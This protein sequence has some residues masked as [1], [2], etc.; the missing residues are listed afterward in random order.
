M[1]DGIQLNDTGNY[2]IF[3]N[4]QVDPEIVDRIGV[5]LGTSD[6]DSPTA[7]ATGGT[8]NLTMVR[9]K[10]EP[11]LE[12]EPSVGSFSYRRLF[13]RGDTGPLGPSHLES[14]LAV[15]YQKY[16]KFKGPGDLEKFQLNGRAYQDLGNDN[17][18]SLSVHYN[19]NRNAFYRNL[20]KAEIALNGYGFDNDATCT[21]P[22][23]GAGIQ[24]EATTPTGT[25]PICTN[26]YNV[27]INPSD[28][29]NIRMQSSF[30][31]AEHLRLTV[32]PSFQ[33]VL[34]NGGGITVIA[35]NDRKLI[36]TGVGGAD[37]NG[38]GDLVDRVQLY[39]PN[40]TN[41]HRF[42]VNSS[43][44]WDLNEF[45]LLRVAY[46]LDYG[47]HRQTGQ[48]G[49]LDANGNPF[50]VFAGRNGVPVVGA[51][52]TQLRG[53][54]RYTLAELNQ[55][56]ISY[57][58][59]LLDEKLRINAGIR[60]PFFK[61]DLTQYCYTS[62]V[63]AQYCTSQ[64][65]NAPNAQGLVTFT[66]VAGTYLPPYSGTKKYN[67]ILPNVG[68]SYEPIE[69]NVFYVSYAKGFSAPRTDNLYNIQ[70]LEVLPETT[71]SYDLGYR[72]DGSK[73]IATAALWKSDY[74]NRIVTSFDPNLGLSVDRN[75]GEVKLW[76]FD[77]SLGV[78]VVHNLKVYGSLSYD[79][80]EVQNNVPFS[81]TVIIPTA[82]K[83]LVETPDWTVGSYIEYTI[84]PVKLGAQGKYV[85]ERFATDV[86]DESA[87]SYIVFDADAHY[88]FK[89]FDV[90]SYVQF[91]VINLTNKQYLGGIATSRFAA[92]T[93][94]PYGQAPLYAVGAPRAF[95]LTVAA[96]F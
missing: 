6:V 14:L 34:A 49:Y 48:F 83:K 81:A 82:G 79:H 7:S 95:Q 77:A 28:T 51:D 33:Y 69:H 50:N 85:A 4:Q 64:I 24:N 43:L 89:M 37:L 87:P 9:P 25:T 55:G 56:S 19:R 5:N 65:P 53:R 39:T 75:V 36:G 38:D 60:A 78:E 72:Y 35:E 57:S 66:G 41:T 91:N 40:T 12:V 17:F 13:L 67:K 46:T 47:K 45:N 22:T 58:G 59:R 32:D 61:R 63:G 30:K 31:L 27:R 71:N 16:D 80:S 11:G 68:V 10:H 54:D 29:G 18:V 21:R 44:L 20:Q 52:G 84:G 23:P 2:A 88:D 26:Y 92:N 86:N 96:K 15:S 74:D 1:L 8:I 93:A 70:I 73:L 94:L 90:E 42:G 3:T 76:G 62:N